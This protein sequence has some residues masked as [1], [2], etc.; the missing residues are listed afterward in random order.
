MTGDCTNPCWDLNNAEIYLT[1]KLGTWLELELPPP[2][3]AVTAGTGPWWPPPGPSPPSSSRRS[4]TGC[5]AL[6]SPAG[7]AA[8]QAAECDE[9]LRSDTESIELMPLGSQLE[10]DQV[11][12]KK[13]KVRRALTLSSLIKQN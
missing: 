4:R 8:L 9:L 10:P 3:G 2:T 11:K 13:S 5:W 12:R 6:P 1:V 7:Q